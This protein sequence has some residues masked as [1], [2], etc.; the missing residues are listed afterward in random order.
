MRLRVIDKNLNGQNGLFIAITEDGSISL[1]S[2]EHGEL[3]HNLTGAYTE[4]LN[5]YTRVAF[6][7]LGII[8]GGQLPSCLNVL[9]C[10][11]GLG[12]N[13]FVLAQEVPPG[14][15]LNITGIELDHRVLAFVPQMLGQSCFRAL[16]QAGLGPAQ[17]AQLSRFKK[18]TIVCHNKNSTLNFNLIQS[19]LRAYLLKA[20]DDSQGK[21]DLVLHD[22]FSPKRM[23]E[24]WTIDLFA[25]CKRRL[26]DG[27]V[28]ITFSSAAAVR[29]AL[30]DLGFHV[31]RTPAL[32]GKW[33][34]TVA[35]LGNHLE[36]SVNEGGLADQI[37]QLSDQEL[38]TLS[39]SSRVPYRDPGLN[40]RREEIV[41]AREA[42]QKSFHMAVGQTVI[43]S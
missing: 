24:L 11:F 2:G 37:M 38:E 20:P 19:C 9:N 23:P 8:Y 16:A 12:Y 35:V 43:R 31:Y 15:D 22:P 36:K 7:A 14:V 10:C 21:L 17:A 5:N 30:L 6:S 27:G 33:G 4:T 25:A 42:E 13:S 41:S 26:K 3:Y 40:G 18:T 34:G 39:K 1:V 32:G 28:I 29:G